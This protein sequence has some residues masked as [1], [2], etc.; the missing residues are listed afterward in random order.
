VSETARDAGPPRCDDFLRDSSMKLKTSAI[1]LVDRHQKTKHM[2]FRQTLSLVAFFFLSLATTQVQAQKIAYVDVNRILESIQEY[3][4]AQEEIDQLA[5]RW[6]QEIAEEYDVIKGMYN[7]YQAEQV[8]LS[9]DQRAEREDEIMDREKAVRDLQRE[10]F[11]P[12]GALFRRRRE[13]I[14]PIQDRIYEA[15]QGYA[16]ER[17]YDFIF[18]KSSNA[19]MI[20]T[21][22]T[23]DKT[24]D[25]LRRLSR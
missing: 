20:F 12:E 3:Q 9:D 2:N 8:L 14:Q 5:A 21:N 7:K 24:D 22:P 25:I 18:D 16:E 4:T 11:G 10:R 19:G 1:G 13:L 23:Y 6:R 17:D 15:I